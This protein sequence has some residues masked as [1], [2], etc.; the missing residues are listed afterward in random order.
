MTGGSGVCRPISLIYK[1]PL[2][3][4][5]HAAKEAIKV[6]KAKEAVTAEN[7]HGSLTLG[8]QVSSKGRKQRKQY[9]SI[10]LGACGMALGCAG[11]PPA[12]SAGPTRSKSV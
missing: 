9:I 3:K 5:V 8:M 2:R 10:A 6:H 11:F 7:V 12:R 1:Q 4:N